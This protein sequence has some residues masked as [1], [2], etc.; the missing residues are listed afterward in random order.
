MQV[1]EAVLFRSP[2]IRIDQEVARGAF[3]FCR[4]CSRLTTRGRGLAPSSQFA[5]VALRRPR[6]AFLG[7]LC[8][9]GFRLAFSATGGARLRPCEVSL[10]WL[11]GLCC[12]VEVRSPK[13]P[14]WP[15][16]PPSSRFAPEQRSG[17]LPWKSCK[18]FSHSGRERRPFSCP[19][20]PFCRRG[21][22]WNLCLFYVRL[23]KERP[24]MAKI[25]KKGSLI[26]I[27]G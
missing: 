4:S 14:P 12:G 25:R 27:F 11:G 15:S 3:P 16:S 24:F 1:S 18:G 6:G 21:R 17:L 26:V 19:F 2:C 5:I 22:E 20:R 10:F 9:L 8:S 23:G 13:R 7:L